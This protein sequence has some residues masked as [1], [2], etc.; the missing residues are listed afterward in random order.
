[1]ASFTLSSPAFPNDAAVTV[2]PGSGRE[3]AAEI[4]YG[5]G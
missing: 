1:M 5:W 4:P 2:T 3:I